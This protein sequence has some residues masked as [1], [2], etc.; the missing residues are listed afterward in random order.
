MPRRIRAALVAGAAAVVVGGGALLVAGGGSGTPGWT[1]GPP[2]GAFSDSALTDA[3]QR[4]LDARSRAI[5]NHDRAAF[6]ATLA[7]PHGGYGTAQL[8]DYDRMT[9]L[10]ISGAGSAVT[11]VRDRA[12]GTFV[13]AV[14]SSY[15]LTDYD[16]GPHT[17][18]TAF[19]FVRHGHGW[20]LTDPG[21][22]DN[23]TEAQP[24]DLPGMRV[25]RSATTLVIGNVSVDRLEAYRRAVD[26]AVARVGTVWHRDWPHRVVVVAPATVREALAQLGGSRG[27][28]HD[29]DD[30]AAETSGTIPSGGVA[31]SDRVVVNPAAF[32]D[33]REEGRVAVLAHETT[34]VAVRSSL[35]GRVPLWLSE[36]FADF[37][38][39]GSIDVSEHAVV[40]PLRRE[41]RGHG[42]PQRLPGDA[43]FT[44][45][46][47]AAAYNEGWLAVR[48]IDRE[49]GS[50]GLTRFYETAAT[51]GGAS[52]VRRST[53]RAFATVLHTSESDFTR[54]W[55]AEVAQ[56]TS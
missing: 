18:P 23:A 55:V 30:V 16:R 26:D 52:D 31:T 19:A 7:D 35:P 27:N 8:A 47:A 5:D 49:A 3:A 36:G 39:Y 6:A 54:R 46:S 53:T 45:D 29:L 17:Y 44:G 43:A 11:S 22:D 33:L 13:A 28:G 20:L 14:D 4:V 12:D 41:V 48:L 32:D 40:E 25:A 56:A 50:T 37:V 1:P 24:W 10:P 34:H 2:A 51:S 15:L 9:R 38:G 42:L 21:A